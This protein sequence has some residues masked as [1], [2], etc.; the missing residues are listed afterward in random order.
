MTKA[1]DNVKNYVDKITKEAKE[2]DRLSN[3]EEMEYYYAC[4]LSK[5][6]VFNER[7]SIAKFM[8]LSIDTFKDLHEETARLGKEIAELRGEK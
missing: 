4:F 7:E 3:I 5:S 6:V 1:Q 2:K 8:E